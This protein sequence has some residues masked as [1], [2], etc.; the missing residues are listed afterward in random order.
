MKLST[1][2][3][4]VMT[5][6]RL[7]L[8]EAVKRIASSYGISGKVGKA[9]YNGTNAQFKLEFAVISHGTAMTKE[10]ASFLQ[11]ADDLDML[12]SDLGKKFIERST[13][14]E[15]ELVGYNPGRA[16]FPFTGREIS[17]GKEFKFTKS[18]IQRYFNAEVK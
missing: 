14:R 10:A 1:I 17:T 12:S 13:G 7:E 2:S 9:I 6:L 8:D 5:A 18:A 15:F 3:L 11:H 16:K 4:D